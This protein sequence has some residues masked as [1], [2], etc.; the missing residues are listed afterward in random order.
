[1]AFH[2]WV[3]YSFSPQTLSQ[4]RLKN[5]HP[6]V[7]CMIQYMHAVPIKQSICRLRLS[8]TYIYKQH[9]LRYLW[10]HVFQISVFIFPQMSLRYG[11][12][13]TFLAG[14][15]VNKMHWGSQREDFTHFHTERNMGMGVLDVCRQATLS[16]L[17]PAAFILELISILHVCHIY[18][19]AY[20][21]AAGKHASSLANKYNSID[22]EQLLH[23]VSHHC[24]LMCLP[25][26]ERLRFGDRDSSG[27]YTGKHLDD[28]RLFFSEQLMLM[29]PWARQLTST[30]FTEVV[31]DC[32][33]HMWC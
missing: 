25:Q 29:F 21:I 4:P 11:R 13:Q 28:H 10:Y 31:E 18:L 1:M 9:M 3:I 26:G 6:S 19:G 5:T 8:N 2:I 16:R 27:T 7:I 23:I 22:G 30:C 14:H 17:N 33:S 15:S 24:T 12:V 32:S 20:H